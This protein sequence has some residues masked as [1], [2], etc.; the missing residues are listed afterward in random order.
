MLQLLRDGRLHT[1]ADLH[2][3]LPDDMGRLIN[4]RPHLSSIRRKL[5]PNGETIAVVIIDGF[6]YYQHVKAVE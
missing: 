5:R 3:C 4:I 1:K 6:T 2:A